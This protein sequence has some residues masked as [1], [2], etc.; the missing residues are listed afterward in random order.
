MLMWVGCCENVDTSGLTQKFHLY[1]ST[2]GRMLVFLLV[3]SKL[4]GPTVYLKY[5]KNTYE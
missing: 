2:V 3:L 4:C 5:S 1:K